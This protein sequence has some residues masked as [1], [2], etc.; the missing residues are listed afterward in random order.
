PMQSIEAAKN[1]MRFCAEE[2]G[3]KGVFVRPNPY[4]GRPLHHPDFDEVWAMCQDM[5]LAVCIHGGAPGIGNLGDDRFP[6]RQGPALNHVGAPPWEW[7]GA[8]ASFVMAGICEKFPKLRVAFL[9]AGGGWMLGWL[10]RM[11]RHYE[12]NGMNDT[13]LTV[14]PTEI[15]QRQCWVSFE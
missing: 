5:D 4:N 9:E 6:Q 14:R 12:D 8:T 7:G 3:F 1:E 11:D 15:F 13:P 10:D 2:L